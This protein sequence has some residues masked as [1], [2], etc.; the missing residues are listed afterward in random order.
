MQGMFTWCCLCW[1]KSGSTHNRL[2]RFQVH[3]I[4]GKIQQTTEQ[5]EKVITHELN[6]KE[7]QNKKKKRKKEKNSPAPT[8]FPKRIKNNVFVQDLSCPQ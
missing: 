8:F 2:W 6:C 5:L 1:K 7:N 4:L 3:T